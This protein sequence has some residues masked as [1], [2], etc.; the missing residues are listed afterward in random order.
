MSVYQILATK[1][2]FSQASSSTSEATK[3]L[4]NG[5]WKL[6]VQNIVKHFMWRALNES[7]PMKLIL[8]AQH[9]LLDNSCGL[10]EGFPEDIIHCL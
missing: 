9:I 10:C 1:T 3:P 6:K 8:C 4:W 5:I 7:L 2:L